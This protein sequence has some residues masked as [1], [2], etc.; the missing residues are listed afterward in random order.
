VTALDLRSAGVF[1]AGWSTFV[2]L[3]TPQAI[4]PA[5]ARDLGTSVGRIGLAITVSLLAVAIVAPVA[6]A[7]SDRLG[8]KRVILSAIFALIVP[9]LLVAGSSSLETLLLW[10]F[11]QGLLL[12]FIFAVTVAYVADEC[13]GPEAIRV[14]GLYA[15]GTIFGGFFGRFIAGFISDAAGW[16]MVFVV[17]AGLTALAGCFV[18]WAMPRERRFRPVVGGLTATFTAYRAHLRNRRLLATCFVGFGMLFC[19]VGTFTFINF[20][21]SAPPFS[22]SASQL[23]SMFAVYLLGMVTTPLATR[24]AVRI[25]RRPAVAIALAITAGGVALTLIHALPAIIAG[26]ALIAGGLFT[27]QALAIGFIGVVARQARSS[28]V[29]LYVTTFYIGGAVG[30]VAPGWLW[31]HNGWPG[32][33]FMLAAMVAA[34]S[35]TT[36]LAWRET[37]NIAT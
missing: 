15:S 36:W 32:V 13:E 6:G 16:R 24:I 25:G 17:L 26:M 5:V 1:V 19:V 9:T 31:Q 20:Y 23:G 35:V 21:L 34:M 4:L 18:A 12:P 8:R 33:A 10:R 2:N 3:Y 27:V 7:L 28:A 22:L 29:G 30:G 14:S 37:P 11:A